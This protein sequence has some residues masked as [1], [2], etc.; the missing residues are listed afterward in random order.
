MMM[1]MTIMLKGKLL[2]LMQSCFLFG[3]GGGVNVAEKL[4][5]PFQKYSNRNINRKISF[6]TRVSSLLDSKTACVAYK[7]C[8]R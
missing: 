3:G 4:L 5:S 2:I 6:F 7:L 8:V 1:M